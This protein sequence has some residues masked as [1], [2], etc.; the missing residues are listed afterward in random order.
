[1]HRLQP[2]RRTVPAALYACLASL[3]PLENLVV[4]VQQVDRGQCPVI[5]PAQ[6]EGQP[7]RIGSAAGDQRKLFAQFMIVI[8]QGFVTRRLVSRGRT[9]DRSRSLWAAQPKPLRGLRLLHKPWQTWCRFRGIIG[10]RQKNVGHRILF[11]QQNGFAL[12]IR[13]VFSLIEAQ[14]DDQPAAVIA[15]GVDPEIGR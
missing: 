6:H 9:N 15:A 4:V 10:N 3:S 5:A 2:V 11:F 7:D 13:R 8:A 14:F 1:M 12:D